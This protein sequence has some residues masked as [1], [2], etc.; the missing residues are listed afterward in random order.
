VVLQDVN[1]AKAVQQS[2]GQQGKAQPQKQSAWPTPAQ[3]SQCSPRQHASVHRI[4]TKLL[5]H[6]CHTFTVHQ[7]QPKLPEPPATSTTSPQLKLLDSSTTSESTGMEEEEEI[8]SGELA[9]HRGVGDELDQQDRS[10]LIP[11]A[12]DAEPSYVSSNSPSN[13]FS[14]KPCRGTDVTTGFSLFY[15][16]AQPSA[17]TPKEAAS[18]G[19]AYDLPLLA[20]INNDEGSEPYTE[21]QDDE[22]EADGLARS[23]SDSDEWCQE[24]DWVKDFA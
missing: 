9:S 11:W 7:R 4:M 6:F 8:A 24:D 10:E 14:W 18:S 17:P 15:Y 5:G 3:A 22:D 1:Y 16:E 21:G 12:E 2:S 20:P 19:E 23:A 13:R